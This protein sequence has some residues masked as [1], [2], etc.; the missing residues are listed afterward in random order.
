MSSSLLIMYCRYLTDL[1]TRLE[2]LK[3][4]ID[5]QE[6]DQANRMVDVTESS[7]TGVRPFAQAN[8]HGEGSSLSM[9]RLIEASLASKTSHVKR[10]TNISAAPVLET[11]SKD[12]IR[13]AELPP[14]DVAQQLDSS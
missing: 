7:P 12:D 9:A 2:E 6:R 11:V 4:T 13:P 1:Q 10:A 3:A 14:K 8:Y 5:S